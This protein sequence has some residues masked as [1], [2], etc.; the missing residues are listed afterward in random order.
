MRGWTNLRG[1]WPSSGR[2]SR[3]P[4]TSPALQTPL[5]RL[6]PSTGLSG[7]RSTRVPGGLWRYRMPH[8]QPRHTWFSRSAAGPQKL[9]FQQVLRV[10]RQAWSLPLGTAPHHILLVYRRLQPHSLGDISA[11]PQSSPAASCTHAA[12]FLEAPFPAMS[13]RPHLIV[14]N[15]YY[16]HLNLNSE[17]VDSFRKSLIHPIFI[18]T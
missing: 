15:C 18:S 9:P 5:G 4:L 1:A 11:R 13:T 14:Y 3:C 12:L 8:H 17:N 2:G 7:P 6:P 16:S 10:G